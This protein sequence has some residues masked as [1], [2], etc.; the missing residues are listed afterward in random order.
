MK[1]LSLLILL[2][3]LCSCDEV[4]R[5]RSVL[6]GNTCAIAKKAIVKETL[7]DNLEVYGSEA[8][9]WCSLGMTYRCFTIDSSNTRAM[10]S[11]DDGSKIIE[12]YFNGLP[13]KLSTES[14]NKAKHNLEIMV[15]E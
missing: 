9:A 6:M 3:T 4:E 11:C 5:E 15:K 8:S 14:G 2:A 1:Y 12:I 13:N 10:F 7:R